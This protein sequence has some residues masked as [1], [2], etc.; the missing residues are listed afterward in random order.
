MKIFLAKFHFL[1]FQKWLK[2]NFWTGKKFKTAKN[3]ISRKKRIYLISRVFQ[4][5]WPAVPNQ[6]PNPNYSPEHNSLSHCNQRR[7]FQWYYNFLIFF[8]KVAITSRSLYCISFLK[9]M[10]PPASGE[11]HKRVII[12]IS[13][14]RKNVPP[15]VQN[16]QTR[17]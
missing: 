13:T 6:S 4:I 17:K 7:K 10:F 1:Q 9:N 2:I 3:V 16:F 11:F 8:I 15:I 14:S 5:F 12:V